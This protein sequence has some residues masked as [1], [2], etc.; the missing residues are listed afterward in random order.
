MFDTPYAHR[1]YF[2]FPALNELQRHFPRQEITLE[3]YPV[4]QAY[5]HELMLNQQAKIK[6]LLDELH[7]AKVAIFTAQT[8]LVAEAVFEVVHVQKK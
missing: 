2:V 1:K 6:E 7:R 5:Y 8:T 3:N 4:I